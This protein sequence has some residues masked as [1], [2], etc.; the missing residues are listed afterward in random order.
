MVIYL[1]T[2]KINGKKYLG[3]DRNN[4]SSYLGGGILLKED[5][6]KYGRGNFEKE[7]IE[8]C[9]D[10]YHLKEREVYW[11]EYYDASNNESFYNL[12]NKSHGS[13]N[14]PT[15]TKAYQNRGKKISQAKKGKSNPHITQQRKGKPLSEETKQKMKKPK[16]KEW[17]EQKIQSMKGKPSPLKGKP[18]TSNY[19]AVLC[20]N[21]NME[22]IKEYPSQTHAEKALNLSQGAVSGGIKQGYKRGGYYWKFKE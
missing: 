3:K 18:H 17:V 10:I 13:D 12:T 6:K 8:V 22:V 2:N 20:L 7:I 15:K 21:G 16:S 9:N 5:I 1:T 11:L 19:K 4:L 14:G